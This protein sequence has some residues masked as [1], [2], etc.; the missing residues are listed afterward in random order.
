MR[1]IQEQY[2]AAIFFGFLQNVLSH[3]LRMRSAQDAKTIF[4]AQPNYLSLIRLAS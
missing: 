4:A 2:E 1:N 3:L